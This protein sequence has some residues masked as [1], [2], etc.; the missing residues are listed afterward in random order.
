VLLRLAVAATHTTSTEP[1]NGFGMASTTLLWLRDDLRIADN[2]AL[3]DAASSGQPILPVYILDDSKDRRAL[4]GAARWWLHHSLSALANTLPLRFF[5]GDPAVILPKIAEAAR[6]SRVV[7]NRRYG[8]A[9]RNLDAGLK[10]AL[11]AQGIAVKSHNGHLMREPWEVKSKAGTHFRVYT[12]FWRAFLALGEVDLARPQPAALTFFGGPRLPGEQQLQELALLPRNPD[13]AASFSNEWQP[14][15]SGA[16]QR[17]ATF[18]D[19]AFKGYA[20]NRNRPDFVSTSRLSPHIRF[21][22]ISLRQLW[23]GAKAAHHASRCADDD[24]ETF[25]KELCWREFSYHLLYHHPDLATA[26]HQPKFNSFPW[27]SDKKQLKAWQKGRTGYPIVDAGMRELWQTGFMHNRVRMIV[28]S[29][30][31]K[32]LLLDW[33]HGEDWFWDTLLDADP[34][35]NAASWQWVAGSGADAAPYFRIFNPV[36]QGEKFDPDGIY[37]RRYVPELSEMPSKFIHAPWTAPMGI[38]LTAGVKLGSTYPVAVVDHEKAR[39]LA[40]SAFKSISGSD[41]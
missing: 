11:E 37:V 34:A 8:L 26:N 3:I 15:E 16:K 35:N 4:G 33:R 17:L 25:L 7:W 1:F 39:A 18:T 31:V 9:E 27:R 2:P 38:L 29:F 22:E 28:G 40:L 5:V 12:P 14:G 19:N 21:G 10:S 13:W 41:T 6:S 20:Q 30:L 23:H 24:L 32:H 36:A